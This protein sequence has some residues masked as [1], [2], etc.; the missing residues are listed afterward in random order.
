MNEAF[1]DDDGR[2]Y[3][4][5]RIKHTIILDDPFDDPE[6]LPIPDRSPLPTKEQ[7]A[8]VRL[9]EDE[10]VDPNK[11]KSLDK[12]DELLRE[13][14]ARAQA[15]ILEMV[16]DIPDADVAPP[17]N[18]LFVCKLNPVTTNEDLELIFSRFGPIKSCEIIRDPK[19]G[20]SLQYA[21]IEYEKEEHCEEAFFKMDNVLVDDRRIH[22]DFSQSVAKLSHIQKPKWA[23]GGD[24]GSSQ[25]FRLK[26]PRAHPGQRKY[27]LVF[28][29][30]DD[31]RGGARNEEKRDAGGRE[32]VTA[33]GGGDRGD[34]GDR[35]AG[36]ERDVERSKDRERDRERDRDR[37]RNRERERER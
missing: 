28:D 17:E 9:G 21:F 10:E 15:Q 6:G 32:K 22:V 18:V 24:S 11:D 3:R 35:T 16:G 5:I 31:T 19:T 26:E 2:P 8:T 25:K 30:D 23:Q 37:D 7:L 34:K 33:R 36:Q 1:V 29:H 20:D 14:E 27:G 4:D 12:I 13:K